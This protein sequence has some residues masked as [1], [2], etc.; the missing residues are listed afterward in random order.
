VTYTV[1]KNVK[2]YIQSNIINFTTLC[3]FL[4]LV[5]GTLTRLLEWT[6][7][8]ARFP[9]KSAVSKQSVCKQ[10]FCSEN[11]RLKICYQA[12]FIYLASNERNFGHI[13]IKVFGRFMSRLFTTTRIFPTDC[14]TCGYWY[15]PDGCTCSFLPSPRL[16]SLSW[17]RPCCFN[18]SVVLHKKNTVENFKMNTD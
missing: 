12:V 11:S 15:S 4:P 17:C 9:S 6:F 5:H 3:L 10:T 1:H 2:T 16:R 13:H 14:A 7:I 18:L 8:W